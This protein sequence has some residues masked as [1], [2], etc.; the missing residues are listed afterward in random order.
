MMFLMMFLIS[1]EGGD[2]RLQFFI[3][4]HDVHNF[5]WWK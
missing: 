4:F 2:G 5:S 3:V 1:G